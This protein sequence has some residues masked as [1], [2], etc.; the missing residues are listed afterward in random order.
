MK[1]MSQCSLGRCLW[2]GSV[3]LAASLGS[4]TAQAQ[5][6]DG[7]PLTAL[8]NFPEQRRNALSLEVGYLPFNTYY[9]G[10]SA[11]AGFTRVFSTS[12]SWEIFSGQYVFPFQ[13]DVT[14]E[15]AE[16]YYVNPKSIERLSYTVSSNIQWT[17]FYGKSLWLGEFI[18]HFRG[19]FFVGPAFHATTETS[20]YGASFGFHLETFVKPSLAWILAARD[21][22]R[23]TPS[24]RNDLAF[25][26]GTRVSF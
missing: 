26:A 13:T 23:I 15:L 9:T 7:V 18:R 14:S 4:W 17:A 21:T 19:S 8:E 25:T 20:G 10:L 3:W 11:V 6:I 2:A 24:T 22:L 12:W 16:K 5:S 1:A